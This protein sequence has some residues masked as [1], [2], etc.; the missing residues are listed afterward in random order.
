[1]LNKL[2]N[3]DGFV[4]GWIEPLELNAAAALVEGVL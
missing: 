1:V 2:R 4:E 3:D